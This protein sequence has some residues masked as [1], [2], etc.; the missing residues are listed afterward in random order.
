MCANAFEC[1]LACVPL[2]L[3]VKACVCVCVCVYVCV[4]SRGDKDGVRGEEGFHHVQNIWPLR[5][6]DGQCASVR[7]RVASPIAT[8]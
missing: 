1:A 4:D 6:A 3:R 8:P 7:R 2:S 5:W